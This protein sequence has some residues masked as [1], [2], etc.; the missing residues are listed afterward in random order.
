VARGSFRMF[1][2]F[3]LLHK[4]SHQGCSGF[5]ANF[6]KRQ[7]FHDTWHFQDVQDVQ[8]VQ[9]FMQTFSRDKV[10]MT[11]GIFRMF[12]MFRLF[13][14]LRKLSHESKFRGMWQSH[15]LRR[16]ERR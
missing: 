14:L 15:L 10:S 12:G 2:L 7:S 11:R 5:Y 4:V 3:R 1:R 8:D 9:A 13:R 6:L 16:R